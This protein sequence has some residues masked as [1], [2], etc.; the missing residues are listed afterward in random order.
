MS[1]ENEILTGIKEIDEQILD[2]LPQTE[3]MS[4]PSGMND[5][6]SQLGAMAAS[7]KIAGLRLAAQSLKGDCGGEEEA[8]KA[9][10]RRRLW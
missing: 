2:L 5:R 1:I 4:V 9:K 8:F 10:R 6:V 3:V 7:E